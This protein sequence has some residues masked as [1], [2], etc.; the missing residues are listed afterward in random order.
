MEARARI[1]APEHACDVGPRHLWD[2]R[3][4]PYHHFALFDVESSDFVATAHCVIR[5]QV[6]QDFTWWI[7]SR[8]RR[9]AYWRSLA[10]DLA[11]YLKKWH[12]IEKVGYIVFGRVHLAA[13]EK[14]AQRLRSHFEAPPRL[15]RAAG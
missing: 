10:D 1:Y 6:A 3:E 7:D 9:Q 13:S 8:M 2:R 15:A 12:R 4:Q 11:A 5:G 14:I